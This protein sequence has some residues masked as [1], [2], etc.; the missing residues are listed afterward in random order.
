MH[1]V[2]TGSC[3]RAPQVNREFIYKM[4]NQ[5]D[6]TGVITNKQIA[7]HGEDNSESIATAASWN[8]HGYQCGLCS[9]SYSALRSLN[10][11]LSS[12]AH[13]QNIYHCPG[14]GCG[15]QFKALAPLVNHME[16]E[17]CGVMKYQRVQ[18]TMTGVLTGQRMLTF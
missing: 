4:I 6:T 7:W 10:Q 11:H 3:P 12:P 18:Q 15:K 8:G 14:R 17:S 13:K 1:H 2:E 16:S 5:R 9:R